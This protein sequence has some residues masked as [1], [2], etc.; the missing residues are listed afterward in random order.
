MDFQKRIAALAVKFAD[1]VLE[2]FES[3][4]L[5]DFK[6][7]SSKQ[8]WSA[9]KPTK[10]WAAKT[11]T[12]KT[13][14]KSAKVRVDTRAYTSK[15]HDTMPAPPMDVPIPYYPSTD[16]PPVLAPPTELNGTG[17]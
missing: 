17:F 6:R 12:R 7:K 8:N 2:I 14:K 11:S 4:P 5:A 1:E 16:L 10:K 3:A 9:K 13:S 15:K